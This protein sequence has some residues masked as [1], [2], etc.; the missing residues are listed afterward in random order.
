MNAGITPGM[1]FYVSKKIALEANYGFLGYTSS[2]STIEAAGV[3]TKS[4]QGNFGLNLNPNTIRLGVSV[5]F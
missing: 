4:S 1:S 2:S 3:E 5:L